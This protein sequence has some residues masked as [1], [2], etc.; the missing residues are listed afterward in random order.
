MLFKITH[1][2]VLR[3]GLAVVVGFAPH[4]VAAIYVAFV[5]FRAI[6]VDP[7]LGAI[8]VLCAYG[9]IDAAVGIFAAI[10]AS[11]IFTVVPIGI[12]RSPTVTIDFAAVAA[13]IGVAVLADGALREVHALISHQADILGATTCSISLGFYAF[14]IGGAVLLAG[15]IFTLFIFEA[16]VQGRIV[17]YTVAVRVA[18]VRTELPVGVPF[19]RYAAE[20]I[21]ESA[22]LIVIASVATLG[23]SHAHVKGGRIGVRL[24]TD[25]SGSWIAFIVGFTAELLLPETAPPVVILGQIA[26]FVEAAF[27]I[28]LAGI[29]DADELTRLVFLFGF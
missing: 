1:P 9:K 11:S 17:R 14:F 13:R 27:L 26:F 3:D 16:T 28:G 10:D 5:E 24:S 7:T 19:R 20:S 25:H 4:E 22:V 21:E 23:F 8:V 18:A 15:F 2:A 29:P 12:G 6:F